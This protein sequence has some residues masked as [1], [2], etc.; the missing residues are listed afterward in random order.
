[1]AKPYI[2]LDQDWRSDPKIMDYESRHGKA[3][4]VDVIQLYCVLGEM[5]GSID[6]NDN[7]QRLR[8]QSVIGK[9]GKALDRFLDDVAECGI[10]SAESLKIYR[11]IMS[12]RSMRDGAVRKRRRES[13]LAASEKAAESRAE[14]KP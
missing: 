1:M 14:I 11:R 2:K 8:L 13:A 3:S 12:E 4:L 5:F 10:I 9:K 6:L 7:G